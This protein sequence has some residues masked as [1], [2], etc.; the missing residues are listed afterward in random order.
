[1]HD[2]STFGELM[3]QDRNGKLAVGAIASL[4]DEIGAAVIHRD[5]KPMDVSVDMSISYISDAKIN[6]SHL[7]AYSTLQKLAL[8][9]DIKC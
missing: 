5:G 7:L 4:I 1:M 9:G 8:F 2:A 3:M 6:V